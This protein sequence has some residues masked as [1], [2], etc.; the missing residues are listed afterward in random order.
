MCF[1]LKEFKREMA[2]SDSLESSNNPD[3]QRYADRTMQLAGS[4]AHRLPPDLILGGETTN[5][6]PAGSSEF[7]PSGK[8]LR[9]CYPIPGPLKFP[10]LS[11]TPVAP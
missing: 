7:Y 9:L 8:L 6:S 1:Y 11:L 3:D 10:S 5:I 2:E 4:S